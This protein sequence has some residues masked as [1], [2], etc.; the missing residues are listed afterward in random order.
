LLDLF[1]LPVSFHEWQRMAV[2]G[3]LLASLRDF[4]S[5]VH[6]F[7]TR[8][9]IA[10]YWITMRA[11]RPTND[12]DVPRWHT[13]RRF[14]DDEA[15]E[16]VTWKLCSTLLGPSTLFLADGPKARAVQKKTRKAVQKT[17]AARHD[18]RAIRCLGCAGM[19]EN[20][21]L[22]L[23]EKLKAHRVIQPMAGECAFFKVG[24][25]HGA[26]HSEPSSSHCDRIF[27]NVV[28]GSETE[29]R[30]LATRWGMD[31]PRAWSIGVPLNV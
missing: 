27:V 22:E 14:F 5:F 30:R 25:Q 23:A 3:D 21:R 17:K 18:C 12:F 7:L 26:V 31:F 8:A 13:D 28:P 1:N 4:L 11:T 29:M 19:E 15:K 9:G 20:V 10:H 2:N 24:D 6:A 16:D